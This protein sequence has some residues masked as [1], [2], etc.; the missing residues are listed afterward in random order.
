M[1][2][3]VEKSKERKFGKWISILFSGINKILDSVS[4]AI[5][6]VGALQEIKNFLELAK[7]VSDLVKI[8]NKSVRS[9]FSHFKR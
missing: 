4:N 1:S 3:V 8:K 7:E 6:G 9:F 5:P 2:S